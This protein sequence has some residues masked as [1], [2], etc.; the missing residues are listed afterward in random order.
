MIG[1]K[2]TYSDREKRTP[3]T[4]CGPSQRAHAAS[5]FGVVSFY[6]LGNF[7]C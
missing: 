4:E 1:K 5:K 3:Q 6:R 2:W 7:I